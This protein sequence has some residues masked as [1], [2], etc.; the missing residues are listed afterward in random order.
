ME[1]RAI[2]RVWGLDKVFWGGWAELSAIG[3]IAEQWICIFRQHLA[4]RI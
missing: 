3:N 4:A 1:V 2:G